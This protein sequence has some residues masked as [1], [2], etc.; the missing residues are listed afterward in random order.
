MQGHGRDFGGRFDVLHIVALCE[1]R[2]AR[3]L[4]T[5]LIQA[6]KKRWPEKC[7]NVADD[8]R[9]QAPGRNFIYLATA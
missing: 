5:R 6:L 9:G 2:E 4:E 3:A 8:C 1:L 7:L